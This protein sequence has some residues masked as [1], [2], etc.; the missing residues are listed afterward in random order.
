[1]FK[2]IGWGPLGLLHSS[3]GLVTRRAVTVQD[4]LESV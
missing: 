3:P 4:V 1:M 2:T